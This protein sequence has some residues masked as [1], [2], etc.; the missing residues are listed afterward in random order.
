MLLCTSEFVGFAES[1]HKDLAVRI[2][3]VILA[4]LPND[5]RK[6][7]GKKYKIPENCQQMKPPSLNPEIKSCL[8]ETI[9]KRD[10]RISMTQERIATGLAAVAKV[11]SDILKINLKEKYTWAENLSD[12]SKIFADL[13]HEETQI[14]R[15]LILQNIN[16]S[17]RETLRETTADDFLFGEKLDD[18]VKTTKSLQK[19]AQELKIFTKTTP[20]NKS[21]NSYGPP[22]RQFQPKG[23]GGQKNLNQMSK[24]PTYNYRK[25]KTENHKSPPRYQQHKR[26]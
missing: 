10:E 13:L 25:S 9:L 3:E 7:L 2:N 11:T 18:R 5:S 20:N 16:P 19:S 17:L 12:A 15:N 24:R 21:K 8:Q 6:D 4:G 14:R 22:R 26:R 23:L 1:I